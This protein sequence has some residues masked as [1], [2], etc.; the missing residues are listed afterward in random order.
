MTRPSTTM[1]ARFALTVAM[2][3]IFAVTAWMVLSGRVTTA[4]AL[5]DAVMIIIGAV[6]SQ[7]S[8]AMNYWLGTSQGSA[9]KTQQLSDSNRGR[10]Q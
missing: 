1:A 8:Q 9:D 5:R 6:I 10:P 4:Q 3:V 7:F 2:A